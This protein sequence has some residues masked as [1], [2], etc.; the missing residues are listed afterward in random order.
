MNDPAEGQTPIEIPE[1]LEWAREALEKMVEGMP[2]WKAEA[3]IAKVRASMY[4]TARPVYQTPTGERIVEV[5]HTNGHL[6]R[7]MVMRNG[8]WRKIQVFP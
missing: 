1:K 8:S 4:R 7:Y 3:R 6:R 2:K 5:P